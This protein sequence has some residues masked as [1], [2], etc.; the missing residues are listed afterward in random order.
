MPRRSTK[1]AGLPLQFQ[2]GVEPMQYYPAGTF[3]ENRKALE[4]NVTPL[5][6]E[7]QC[8]WY[9]EDHDQCSTSSNPE[10]YDDNIL[11]TNDDH[12]ATQVHSHHMNSQLYRSYD[13]FV[14]HPTDPR[15]ERQ[16]YV[17]HDFDY[18]PEQNIVLST[19]RF[20][21][22]SLIKVLLYNIDTLSK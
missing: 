2:V 19:T 9:P 16:L 21:V 18:D 20:A 17:M 15:S 5:Q 11:D 14:R 7:D 10:V 4:C 22:T 6:S 8:E 3:A 13:I 12:I 1:T